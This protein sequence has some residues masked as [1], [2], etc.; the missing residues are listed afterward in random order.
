MAYP[1]HQDLRLPYLPSNLRTS[2]HALS[3]T[4]IIADCNLTLSP[5]L[6]ISLLH[7]VAYVAY[8]LQKRNAIFIFCVLILS[9][10]MTVC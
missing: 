10:V 4:L 8:I 6:Y 2:Q 9:Q 7:S 3:L 5:F 1:T